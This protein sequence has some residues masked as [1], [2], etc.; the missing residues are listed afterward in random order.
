MAMKPAKKI[1]KT[2]LH[3]NSMTN[4]KKPKKDKKNKKSKQP[5]YSSIVTVEAS[6]ANGQRYDSV[7]EKLSDSPSMGRYPIS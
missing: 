5:L 7:N 6:K 1:M 2:F 3:P 4:L